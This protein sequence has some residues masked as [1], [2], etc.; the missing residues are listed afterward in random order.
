MAETRP[1]MERLLALPLLAS[2]L[3]LALLPA[4]WPA[5]VPA[6]LGPWLA[7]PLLALGCAR[8]WPAAEAPPRRLWWRDGLAL[9]LLWGLAFALFGLA[10]VWP[11]SSLLQTGSLQAAL[12]LGAVAGFAW[13]M[14]WRHWTRFALAARQGGGLAALA[15]ALP[16]T[17]SLGRGLALGAAVLAVL[18]TGW[19]LVLPPPG[20]ATPW[21][22]ALPYALGLLL[23]HAALQRHGEPP[24]LP[25]WAP[26]EDDDDSG[27]GEAGTASGDLAAGESTDLFAAA[28][29]GRIDFVLEALEAGADPD[30]CP[31]PDAPDQRTLAMLAA[32]LPDLRLLRALIAAGVDLNQEHAG[33]TPLLAATRD[34]WHGRIDAVSMLLANGADP[35]HP[36]REGNTPLHHAARSTDPAVAAQLLDA[37]ADLAALNAEGQSPLAA[38][39]ASGNA[40]MARFLLER[41]ARPELPGAVPAL[42]AAAAGEDDDPAGV[43]LL[44]RHKARVDARDGRGRSALLE[45]IALGHEA[46]TRA[47]LEAGAAVGLADAEGRNALLEAAASPN[48]ALLPLVAARRPDPAAT[49][50]GGRNALALACLAGVEPARLRAL[51]DLGV[52]PQQRD[53]AGRR[54]VDHAIGAGRW[55]LVAVLDP[56]AALPEGSLEA[57]GPPSSRERLRQ[58]LAEGDFATAAALLEGADPPSRAACSM[59]LLEFAEADGLAAATWLLHRGARLDDRIAGMDSVGLLLLDR[60]L[61][62]AALLERAL[63]AGQVPQGAG[64]LARWLAASAADPARAEPLALGLLER[65]VDPF[66]PAPGGEPALLLAAGGGQ[67]CLLAALL[68]RGLDPGARDPRGNTALHRAVA[69][70]DAAMVRQLVRHGAPAEARAADGQTPHGLAVARGRHDLAEWLDWRPWRLPGRALR[71]ADLPAAAVAGDLAAVERL[72][73]LGLPVDAVD[74]QGCTALLRASGGGHLALVEHL[75]GHRADPALAARTGATPLSAAISMRH[76]AVVDRLLA[77]GAD[78]DQP[79]PGGV[80]P[81][82]LAAAL[83]LPELAAR[84][85]RAG[86][87]PAHRDDQGLGALH[88]AALFAFGARER[89]RVLALFDTLLLA[90]AVPDG[91]PPPPAPTPLLLLLGARAE[92]GASHDEDVLLAAV[93]RLLAEGV[94]LDR[95]EQRGLTAL[96]LAALHGMGRVVD[97]L[98]REGANPALR[99]R[100]GRTPA[101]LA[102]LRGFVDIAACFAPGRTPAA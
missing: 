18:A 99:D 76:A 60:G 7:Q 24:R 100:Y 42:L 64:A 65:G 29:A 93:D 55:P 89:A 56:D 37:G 92:A 80:R 31:G 74:A 38:A 25:A 43:L 40:R 46:I 48:P 4:A 73:A 63:Q 97:R 1:A 49:D 62:G 51:I 12:G 67:Q 95:A 41:G 91:D 58:A 34:S 36:D 53:A 28:R 79:M 101:D 84:L 50:H 59:L 85:L 26:P 75:L 68:A 33:L 10:L 90:E 14:A 21:A 72:L 61:A 23:V 54:P 35:R 66:A 94:A 83:G 70:G 52:D 30:A 22:L 39:L 32:L 86:A 19:V 77:A 98:L 44:L 96:H 11:Y 87:D 2:G 9:A 88:C 3:A 13:T 27:A 57:A 45:A 82:M 6:I 17:A 81:L 71:D 69:R 15:A 78:P 5:G 16:G 20:L 8:L 102:L 47:L